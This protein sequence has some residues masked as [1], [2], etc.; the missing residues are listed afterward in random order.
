MEE[1]DEARPSKRSE[2]GLDW[3]N[4]FI[5][6]VQAGFGPFVALYLASL[7]WSQG[8]I[9][10]LLT[11]STLSSIA[12]QAPGGAL[13][14]AAASKRL[15]IGSALAAIA[16]AALIF[17]FFPNPVIIFIAVVLYGS[18]N[19]VIK[20]ALSAIGLGLVGH[21]SFSERVGRNQRY[22]RWGMP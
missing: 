10:L 21:S 6:D 9:G 3:L 12:S 15:L 22:T 2:S 14:D 16:T 17:A 20:P 8:Q 7:N 4:F 19:G 1:A 13:V 11:V 5:A 18:T